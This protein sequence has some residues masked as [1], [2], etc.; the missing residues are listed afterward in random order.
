M[1][2]RTVW[3]MWLCEPKEYVVV[4]ETANRV[5]VYWDGDSGHVRFLRPSSVFNSKDEVLN[6]EL[7]RL[8]QRV[9]YAQEALNNFKKKWGLKQ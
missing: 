7:I 6:D 4:K 8:T 9:Q 5:T 1:T 2:R 3:Q